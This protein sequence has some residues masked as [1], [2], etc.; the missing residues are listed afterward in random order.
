M[1]ATS[2]GRIA[3]CSTSCCGASAWCPCAATSANTASSGSARASAPDP[4][5]WRESF[6]LPALSACV[7][8]VQGG[9]PDRCPCTA[10]KPIQPPARPVFKVESMEGPC[11]LSGEREWELRSLR[12]VDPMCAVDTSSAAE[13]RRERVGRSSLRSP[14]R[15]LPCGFLAAFGTPGRLAHLCF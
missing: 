5:P 3:D 2:G 8:P 1:N 7:A 4:L 6:P 12:A 9:R 10:A 15:G 14:T 11:A 13:A